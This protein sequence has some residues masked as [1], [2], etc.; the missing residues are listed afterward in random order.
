MR[1]IEE[2]ARKNFI[3]KLEAKRL[4]ACVLYENAL[5]LAEQKRWDFSIAVLEDVLRK[6]QDFTPA[7]AL[8]A[9]AYMKQ[10]EIKR[11]LKV[12]VNAWKIAP[13]PLLTESLL[14]CWSEN[15]DRQKVVHGA[16]KLAIFMPEHRESQ[17]L[18]AELS[19]KQNDLRSARAYL[20]HLLQGQETVRVCRLMG[21]LEN[22]NDDHEQAASWLKRAGSAVS[23]PHWTCSQCQHIS[24]SW[25]MACNH[26]GSI[27]SLAWK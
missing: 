25:Q 6:Q 24:D 4:S 18:L 10:G 23:E 7:S 21:E 5:T 19:L 8:L 26:C 16:E 27:A 9:K 20:N 17:F 3:G 15:K 11:A 2:S 1:L 12:I 13:H 22:L 14:L